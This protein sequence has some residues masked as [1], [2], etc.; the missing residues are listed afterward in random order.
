[1]LLKAFLFIALAVMLFN[2]AK[3]SGNF[4]RGPFEEHLCEINLDL[5]QQFRRSCLKIFFH[6]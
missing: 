3:P 4:E 6:F 5:S 1:M 2:R